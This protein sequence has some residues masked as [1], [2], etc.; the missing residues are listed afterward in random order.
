MV[1]QRVYER[2]TCVTGCWVNHQ[3]RRLIDDKNVVI[4]LDHAD[5]NLLRDQLRVGDRRDRK[6]QRATRY[7]G[8]AR[9]NRNSVHRESPLT[10]QSL[11]E[12]S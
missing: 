9:T 10:Y 4:L 11:D 2:P 8:T 3:T 1:Q 7:Q 6:M 12:G 5:R